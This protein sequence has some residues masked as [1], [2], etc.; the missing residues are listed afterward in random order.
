MGA[1]A[2]EITNVLY[3]YA[4]VMD[5]G[6]FAGVAALFHHARVRADASGETLGEDGMRALWE[7]CVVR[8]A[9]GTPVQA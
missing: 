5:R 2:V 1:S 9:D 6:D 8:Y 4:E 3:R 7:H